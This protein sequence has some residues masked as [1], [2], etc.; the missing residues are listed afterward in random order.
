MCWS[1]WFATLVQSSLRN[2]LSGARSVFV[3]VNFGNAGI[4]R[5]VEGVD[6]LSIF[7]IVADI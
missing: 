1:K 4:L 5:G 2:D 6:V 7:S 3:G